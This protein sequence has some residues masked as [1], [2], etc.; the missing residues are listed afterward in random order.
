M[1]RDQKDDEVG[2][3]GIATESWCFGT[4]ER[5]RYGTNG[6]NGNGRGRRE[7]RR[8]GIWRRRQFALGAAVQSTEPGGAERRQPQLSSPNKHSSK[9]E[10]Y[11]K[12]QLAPYILHRPESTSSL[13]MQLG[14]IITDK[15]VGPR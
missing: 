14:W 11:L 12:W 1:G 13:T 5:V 15:S 6:G 8:G 10:R 3:I 2:D 4:G 9:Q 7:E